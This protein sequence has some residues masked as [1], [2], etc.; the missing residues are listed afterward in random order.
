M[1]NGGGKK[2]AER[3]HITASKVKKGRV[4]LKSTSYPSSLN[5]TER[6]VVTDVKDQG[7][8][9]S[10]WAFGSIAQAESTLILNGE[11]DLTIDLSEQYLVECTYASDCSGTYYVEYV[12]D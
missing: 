9:G 6:G 3:P 4:R 11:A 10:C 2:F 12:M 5:W 1:K 8:C 7:A